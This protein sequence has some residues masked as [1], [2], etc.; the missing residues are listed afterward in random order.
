M[1]VHWLQ[2]CKQ[3]EVASNQIG[4]SFTMRE[5]VA[6]NQHHDAVAGTEK[7][8]VANDYIKRI[9]NGMDKCEAMMG[10]ASINT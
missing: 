7:Q 8:H 10:K 9:V 4:A 2:A 1:C 6:T 3:V 5:S